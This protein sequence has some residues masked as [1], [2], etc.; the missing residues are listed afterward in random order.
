MQTDS[1]AKRNI[2]ITSNNARSNI[3]Q[4]SNFNSSNFII[5]DSLLKIEQDDTIKV[6]IVYS[7]IDE[8]IHNDVLLIEDI[9]NNQTKFVSI[10]GEGIETELTERDTSIPWKLKLHPIPFSDGTELT[11][12]YDV[13]EERKINITLYNLGG[14]PIRSIINDT[15]KIGYH[16]YSWDCK[17]ETGAKVEAGEYL[18]VMQS[19]MFIQIQHLMI[20]Y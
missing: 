17:D 13:P 7:P 1:T 12:K 10:F 16:T 20:L 18:C 14:R 11:V 4:I 19:G 3:L 2:W 15:V 6:S 5:S 9:V 8:D